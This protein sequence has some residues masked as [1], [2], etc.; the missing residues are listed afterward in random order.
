MKN[1]VRLL[2]FALFFGLIPLASVAAD[3]NALEPRLTVE[4]RDGS[5]IVGAPVDKNF[6]F[7]SPLLGD[8][9][10][11]VTDIRSVECLATNRAKLITSNGDTLNAAFAETS[12]A[13]KT[14]FGKIEVS[15]KLLRKLTVSPPGTLSGARRPGLVAL[16]S[17][18][19]SGKDSAG[20][21]DAELTDVGFS[22]GKVGRA[23]LLE[24]DNAT[25]RIPASSSLNVGSGGGFTICAWINP[26]NVSKT[27]PILECVGE[28]VRGDTQ[29][30]I[31]PP[32]GGPGTLYAMLSDT[33][34]NAHYFSCPRAVI[35]NVFQHVAL[36]YDKQSGI[37]TIYCN[38]IAVAQ[39]PL[40][41]FTPQ[42]SCDFYVGK[43]PLIG[44]E[45]WQFTGIIDEASIYNRA[46][47][48]SEIRAICTSDNHGEPL[49]APAGR[50][51]KGISGSFGD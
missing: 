23:F 20:N 32:H 7:R 21:H 6:R 44:G 41:Y 10:L 34:G 38:G 29:F 49:P 25:I 50:A 9:K 39:Q 1:L 45:T 33:D 19:D 22:E 12:F 35:P 18:E 36:T 31:Y 17:G 48:T 46:L 40:G 28:G 8:I 13:L 27:S 5:R 3:T 14:G 37:G 51:Y 15:A 2:N 4:L 16:W 30:Y 43:R 24:G 26:S 42:T 11:A 47:S